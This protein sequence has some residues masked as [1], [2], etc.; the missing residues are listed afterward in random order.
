[1]SLQVLIA[2]FCMDGFTGTELFVRD[3]ALELLRQGH[4]PV[5]YTSSVGGASDELSTAGIHVATSLRRLDFRPY[6]IHGNHRFETLSAIRHFPDTPA[7]YIC[8]DHQDWLSKPPLHSHILRYFGVSDLCLTRLRTSGIPE[9]KISRIYNFVDLQRFM[10]RPPLP[11]QPGRALVFS[12]YAATETYLPIV[13]E[14][15]RQA[16]L[17]LDVVGKGAG[18]PVERPEKILGQYDIVFAK[19]K[20][21][22]EAMAVGNAVVLCDFGGIGPIVT[23]ADFARL[24]DM[25]FGYQALAEPHT[26]ENLLRQ[27]G[28]YDRQ[29]AEKVRDLLRSCAGLECSV[30]E[31]TEIYNL[32]ISEYR[33]RRPIRSGMRDV[34][35]IAELA[36]VPLSY[37]A[38]NLWKSVPPMRRRAM[39]NNRGFRMLEGGIRRILGGRR[40]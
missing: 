23:S 37:K 36:R 8:H 11:E 31:L 39:S 27:I 20:A 33:S 32:V 21:A 9:H 13:A 15:C 28:R 14:A 40:D 1:V 22:M 17:E 34:M 16:D 38:F 29:D 12:N 2:N 19:A 4:T 18:N 24:R 30:D 6:I 7:L 25:N 5:V 26:P 3:L 35:S 10:P